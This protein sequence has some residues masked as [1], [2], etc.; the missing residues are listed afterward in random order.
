MVCLAAIRLTEHDTQVAHAQDV[1][2]FCEQ[3]ERRGQERSVKYFH[4]K[5]AMGKEDTWTDGHC[6]IAH[7]VVATKPTDFYFLCVMQPLIPSPS[8]YL[9]AFA[10]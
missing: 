6:T 9:Y 1:F 7:D 2:V 4:V 8:I 10:K 3:M 5:Q